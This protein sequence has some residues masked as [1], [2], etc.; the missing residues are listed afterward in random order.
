MKYA[1]VNGIVLDGT[2]NM[3]PVTGKAVLV[4]DGKIKDIVENSGDFPDHEIVDLEGAYL[5][6]GLID[7]HVHI[8]IDGKPPK[9]EKKPTNYKLLFQV[10]SKSRVVLNVMKRRAAKYAETELLSGVTTIRTVGGILDIDGKVRD[11]I[12]A[13]KLNGPRILAANTGVSVPGGHFAGSIA[14][15]AATPEEARQHVR[16]I[17]RTNPDLIKLM[18]TGGVMDASEE[19]EPGVLRMSPEIVKA[20]CEEAHAFGYKVAAHVESPEGVRVALENGVDTIEHGAKLDAEMIRLFKEKGASPVCTISPALPYAE[21]ELSESHALPVAKKNGKIVMDGIIECA[22]T[23]IENGIPV[24][25]GNDVGC[26]FIL[27]Y[28]YWRELCYF[29]KYVGVSNKDTLYTATLGN[30]KIVGIDK[31]TGSIEKGKSADM[32]VVKGD[33]LEDLSVIRNVS[34][35]MIKGK[36]IRDPQIRKMTEVDD[37]LDKYM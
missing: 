21:F 4:E 5:L 19:G 15:E 7:L 18:I 3:V 26:P 28:N 10:L 8:A 30:A 31:E 20:A 35:V 13:G 1:F 11:L 14:T 24:G 6:P 37:L 34:A 33:P 25:L 22:K 29:H 16:Q 27:H 23:C 32:I 12:N 36:L 2:K 9:K 17:A